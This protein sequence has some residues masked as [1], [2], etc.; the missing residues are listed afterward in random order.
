MTSKIKKNVLNDNQHPVLSKS[1]KQNNQ[2]VSKYVESKVFDG[3]IR[4]AIRILASDDSQ[5]EY[6]VAIFNQLKQK[7][8]YLQWIQKHNQTKT[9]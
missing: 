5:Q 8:G 2:S 9:K 6:D 3:D 7:H 4:G 1:R